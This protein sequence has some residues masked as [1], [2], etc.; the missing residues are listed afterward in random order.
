MKKRVSLD[1]SK[2]ILFCADWALASAGVAAN[3]MS[4]GNSSGVD[5][6]QTI[7]QSSKTVKGVVMDNFGPV[8]GA[9][10]LV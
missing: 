2:R 6:V 7:E 10:V 5:A 4:N 9:N 8:P 1:F 3:P